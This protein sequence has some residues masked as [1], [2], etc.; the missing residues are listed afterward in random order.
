MAV[1]LLPATPGPRP[2]LADVET[3]VASPIERASMAFQTGRS[4]GDTRS[5]WFVSDPRAQ[6]LRAVVDLPVSGAGDLSPDGTALVFVNPLADGRSAIAVTDIPTGRT[7]AYARAS[8]VKTVEWSPSGSQL[9]V[10]EKTNTDLL[11]RVTVVERDGSLVASGGVAEGEQGSSLA[12]SPDGSQV[13]ML[14]CQGL[15]ACRGTVLNVARNELS[16]TSEPVI[17]MVWADARH[18]VGERRFGGALVTD[19][20]GVTQREI[21]VDGR[22]AGPHAVSPD[23]KSILMLP[24]NSGIGQT[25]IRVVNIETGATTR[26]LVAPQ[27]GVPSVLGWRGS[28]V[29]VVRERPGGLEV[30]RVRSTVAAGEVVLV[31]PFS[32]EGFSSTLVVAEWFAAG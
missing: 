5:S 31:R 7:T 4:R 22:P 2:V 30:V 28:D 14:G 11:W 24:S 18:L 17:W 26:E 6:T 19:T 10:L 27:D 3:L 29:L 16:R 12:W 32:G 15:G 9:A 1:E 21:A 25:F 8:A 23:G 13:A 20:A